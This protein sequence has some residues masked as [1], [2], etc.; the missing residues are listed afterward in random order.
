MSTTTE[1]AAAQPSSSEPDASS[2]SVRRIV[3]S[4]SRSD[5]IF[6]GGTFAVAVA[7]FVL[8]F[9]IG[10]FLLLKGL[11][12]TS[13]ESIGTFLT[14]TSFQPT[15]A[16]PVVGVVSLLYWTVV[17]AVIAVIVGVPIAVAAALFITE[18][19]PLRLRRFLVTLID[20]LA[21]VPSV[22]FGLWGVYMLQPNVV[23]FSR[24]LSTHLSFI[25]IFKVN[26]AE[27]T[28][29][30]FIA[31]LVVGIMIVPIVAS[32]CREIFSLAPPGEREG[33]LALGSTRAG[34]I[35]SVVLPFGRGGLIGAIM[36]GL[37]RALGET[38][39][40]GIIVSLTLQVDPH[41]LGVGA[42]SIAAFIALRFST[43]GQFGLSGLMLAGFVL[44]VFTMAVNFAASIVVNRSRT[45]ESA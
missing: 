45:G 35:R 6:R 18:Y 42:N 39:A 3:A 23:G 24:F 12:I 25:P 28:S 38:I 30:A 9:L 27:Y 26:T 4:H 5:R 33:A 40:I 41:I 31:G 8:L 43:G 19:A 16:H 34:V 21:V 2:P 13:H 11:G 37:G 44:F 7:A 32:I 1:D 10:L 20:L 36:L 29:S 14:S 17:I 22:I 15:G